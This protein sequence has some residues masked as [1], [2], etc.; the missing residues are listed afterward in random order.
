MY[1]S[2]AKSI[3]P[4][5]VCDRCKKTFVYFNDNQDNVYLQIQPRLTSDGYINHEIYLCP[6]C[7]KD[8]EVY[9]NELRESN[10][11]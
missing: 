10:N 11:E 2:N 8:F 4:M 5:F 7:T 1:I 9:M 3:K 6:N